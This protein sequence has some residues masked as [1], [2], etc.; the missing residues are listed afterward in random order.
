MAGPAKSARDQEPLLMIS[1]SIR[2]MGYT[3]IFFAWKYHQTYLEA[4]SAL[5]M[6]L[7]LVF[8]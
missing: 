5:S 4:D 7:H 3:P 1:G 8:P 6:V 2:E